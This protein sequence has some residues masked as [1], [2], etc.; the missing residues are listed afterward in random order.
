[1]VVVAVKIPAQ[2]SVVFGA[3]KVM[4]PAALTSGNTI[5]SGA[6]TSCIVIFCFSVVTFPFP[7]SK[8]HKTEYVPTLL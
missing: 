6:V 2:L 1:M 5:K 4:L 8:D 3:T 7:S